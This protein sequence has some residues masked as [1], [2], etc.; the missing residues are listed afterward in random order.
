[1]CLCHVLGGALIA[2]LLPTCG[3]VCGEDQADTGRRLP[4][5]SAARDATNTDTRAPWHY[6]IGVDEALQRVDARVCFD[7][8]A[9]HALRVQAPQTVAALFA[10][11]GAVRPAP[12]ADELLLDRR[13]QLADGTCVAY[14]VDIAAVLAVLADRGR[15]ARLPGA[16]MA[17]SAASRSISSRWTAAS[18]ASPDSASPP[19]PTRLPSANADQ[20]SYNRSKHLGKSSLSH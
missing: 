15:R 17:P 12:A 3:R 18:C 19:R 2:L 13:A 16:H 14:A 8:R 20:L 1:M 7:G 4:A 5:E 10:I 6:R 11:Q 9:P